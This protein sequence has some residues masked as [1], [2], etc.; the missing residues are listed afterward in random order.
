MGVNDD[1]CVVV[2]M[3]NESRVIGSVVAGLRTRFPLILCVDDGSVD[4]SA[5]I[6]RAAGATVVRHPIN[7]GQGAAL[8]TGI[9]Y[10]LQ[11]DDVNFIVTF[12][13]DGQHSVEDAADMVA[14]MRLQGTDAILGSRFLRPGTKTMPASRRLVLRLGVAFTRVTS[15]LKVTDT[16]NGLRAL[17]RRAAQSLQITLHGMAHASQILDQIHDAKLSYRE[18]PVTIEYSDYSKAKGQS[19][20]NA[21]NVLFDL[22]AHRLRG[23]R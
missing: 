6:A 16:H 9:D 10:A 7:L 3:L 11:H 20:I 2:P 12:D 14:A 23:A 8:Q 13:A 4:G 17:N 21:F 19:N 22:L 18:H 15:G 1:V 5:D